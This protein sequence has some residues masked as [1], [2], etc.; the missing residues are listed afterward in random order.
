MQHDEN[1][2]DYCSGL[3]HAC[4]AGTRCKSTK[5]LRS[6]ESAFT[7]L[8][9][10]ENFITLLEAESLTE[11]PGPLNALFHEAKNRNDIS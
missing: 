7:K 8:F 11:I 10:D 1:I 4:F 5:C 6:Y 3:E 9:E 2:R